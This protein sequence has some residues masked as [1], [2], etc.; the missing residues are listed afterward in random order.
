MLP[1]VDYAGP[2]AHCSRVLHASPANDTAP[3]ATMLQ[4]HSPMPT[5]PRPRHLSFP[6]ALLP[7]ASLTALET[8]RRASHALTRS[9][10]SLEDQCI[11][12]YAQRPIALKW[13][14]PNHCP[15]LHLSLLIGPTP[16]AS[17]K[18]PQRNKPPLNRKDGHL[19][20]RLPYD[21]LHS[22]AISSAA[23]PAKYSHVPVSDAQVPRDA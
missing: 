17:N 2:N 11:R 13:V 1:I 8:S 12:K 9:R 19:R 15:I 20:L 4:S 5:R 16:S 6:P 18:G 3:P 14:S 10:S 7:N 22:R 23:V 21:K